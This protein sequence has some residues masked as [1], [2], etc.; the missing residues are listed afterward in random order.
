MKKSEVLR[1]GYN[2]GLRR[3][4]KVINE[5]LD[6]FGHTAED[7]F[8]AIYAGNTSLVEEIIE[9]GV[10]V[11]ARNNDDWTALHVAA[12]WG[13]KSICEKLLTLGAAVDATERNYD[14]TPLHAT[15]EAGY[16]EIVE[17]LL[18]YGADANA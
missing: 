10:D 1:E 16:T 17:L 14:R 9:S 5:M 3:A 7:L 2:N 15:T 6:D 18:N 11:N 13:R 4:M 8:D 12:R